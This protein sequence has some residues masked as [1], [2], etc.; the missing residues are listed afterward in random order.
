MKKIVII[1]SL[2]FLL[3]SC[4]NKSDSNRQEP[5]QNFDWLTGNWIR[6]NNQE[7]KTTYENWEKKSST[8]YSGFSYTM[9][10]SDTV[11]QENVKL[12]KTNGNWSFE[13]TGKGE[14][15]PTKFKLITIEKEKFVCQNKA[16]EF[17]KIIEYSKMEDKLQAKISGDAMEILFDFEKLNK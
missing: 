11:W 2:V 9:Q 5:L 4:N 12:I 6:T 7:N 13:V 17:P 10:N 15:E 3:T 14:T 16:N 1:V 8:E